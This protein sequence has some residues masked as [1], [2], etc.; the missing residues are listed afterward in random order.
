MSEGEVDDAKGFVNVPACVSKLTWHIDPS[1]LG[2][3]LEVRRSQRS[4]MIGRSDAFFLIVSFIFT[5]VSNYF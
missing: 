4:G 1:I 5:I 3:G 2:G